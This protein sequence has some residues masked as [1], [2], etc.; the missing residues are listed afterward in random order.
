MRTTILFPND[1]TKTIEALSLAIDNLNTS[2][3][4]RHELLNQRE[5]KLEIICNSIRHNLNEFLERNKMIQSSVSGLLLDRL[6]HEFV[7]NSVDARATE[8]TF[9]LV[10]NDHGKVQITIE[11]NGTISIPP[12]KIGKYDWREA[13]LSDSIKVNT[14]QLGGCNLGLA[15]GANMAEILGEGALELTQRNEGGARTAF[16][17]STKEY[18]FDRFSFAN[19]ACEMIHDLV[20]ENCS[21]PRLAAAKV[22]YSYLEDFQ[23]KRDKLLNTPTPLSELSFSQL[24]SSVGAFSP[25]FN[26]FASPLIQPSTPSEPTPKTKKR[27]PSLFSPSMVPQTTPVRNISDLT[28]PL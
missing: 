20:K 15:F 9:A 10:I 18:D 14:N 27:P 6:L 1:Y 3:E 24:V 7:K 16:T 11:D 26:N 2:E 19:Y 21:D 17:T 4:N 22:K 25:S 8:M 28:F 5:A 13:V 23:S 12:T